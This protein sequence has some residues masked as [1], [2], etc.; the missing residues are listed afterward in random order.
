MAGTT[1][2]TAIRARSSTFAAG[3]AGPFTDS[4][5]RTCHTDVPTGLAAGARATH[6]GEVNIHAAEK[7]LGRHLASAD[8]DASLVA[9]ELPHR[10]A[11]LV[12]GDTLL[13]ADTTDPAEYHARKLE[14]LGRVHDGSDPDGRD[15]D[16]DRGHRSIRTRGSGSRFYP[17]PAITT[18]EIG[19][20]Q[21]WEYRVSNPLPSRF[22]VFSR[23]PL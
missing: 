22:L 23:C 11:A 5:R 20:T 16:R 9:A 18:R 19:C 12:A 14:G 7:R 21:S 6:R 1:L 2:A 4:R 3:V 15:V 10:S 8:W 17:H 13:V